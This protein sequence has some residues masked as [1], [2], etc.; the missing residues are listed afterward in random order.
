[1][2]ILKALTGA[3]ACQLEYTE[4]VQKMIADP[5]DEVLSHPDY[6]AIIF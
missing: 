6:A 2:S 3:H 4:S 5:I 1:M